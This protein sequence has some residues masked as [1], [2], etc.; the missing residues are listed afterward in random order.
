[1][2][3]NMIDINLQ[4]FGGRGS[5]SGEISR[6]NRIREQIISD[7]ANSKLKGLA[8]QAR[9]NEGKFGA[10]SEATAIKYADIK[11]LD[12]FGSYERNGNTIV[13]FSRNNKARFYAN[14][15]DSPEIRNLLKNQRRREEKEV[16]EEKIQR[17]IMASKQ[18]ART[19]T[20]DVWQK[21]NKRKFDAWF[22]GSSK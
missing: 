16:K 5:S 10:M 14:K 17:D 2:E 20:Y 4:F 12:R 8:R 1:M 21:R 22:Y 9:N 18:G 15:S 11:G 7:T 19:T 13:Y 3:K 6:S